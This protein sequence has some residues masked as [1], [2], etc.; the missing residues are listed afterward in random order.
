MSLSTAAVPS[1]LFD[2]L[3]PDVIEAEDENLIK[4][5]NTRNRSATR[6][7]HPT[8]ESPAAKKQDASE[9]STVGESTSPTEIPG[10]PIN[11]AP[12]KSKKGSIWHRFKQFVRSVSV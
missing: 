4:E 1:N 6:T 3:K 12:T 10:F 11:E 9:T 5:N 2:R 8:K 7:D